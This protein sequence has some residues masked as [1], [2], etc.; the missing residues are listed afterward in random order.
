MNSPK[1]YS[2]RQVLGTALALP[3]MLAQ[4][5]QRADVPP[6]RLSCLPVSFFD[7]IRSGKMPLEEWL[8]F[9]AELGLDGV[10]CG[11]PLLKP[12]GPGTPES[13][14]K[15]AEA[16][17][18]AVSNYSSYSDFTQPDADAREREVAA[19]ISNVRLA[20]ELGA[21]SLRALTGQ[22]RPEVSREQGI[23]WVAECM[24]RVAEAADREGMRLNIENHTKASTWTG[25]DFAIQSEVYLRIMEQLADTSVGV[26]FD[27]ANPLV[28][29]EETLPLFEKLKQR[30]HYVHLNDVARPGVFEFV[31]LGTGISPVREV[32]RRLYLQKYRGW[33]AIEEYSRTGKEGFRSAVRFARRALEEAAGETRATG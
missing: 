12:L 26:Q 8:D 1:L 24:R 30:I 13:F 31:V 5:Q 20:K 14:R 29:K 22:Q 27:T 25:F 2:R 33:V 17:H 18:L 16:R 19:M 21:P 3:A 28:A 7:A 10:E 32:V 4:G 6:V 9:A 23:R 15:L 11:P